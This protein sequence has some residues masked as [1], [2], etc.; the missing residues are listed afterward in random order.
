MNV[1]RD[2]NCEL[3]GGTKDSIPNHVPRCDSTFFIDHIALRYFI[4]YLHIFSL[5]LFFELKMP[6]LVVWYHTLSR[7]CMRM[8]M[9][10]GMGLRLKFKLQN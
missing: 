3:K 9:G 7:S 1:R 10:R 2:A 6:V 8:S 4:A 5:A